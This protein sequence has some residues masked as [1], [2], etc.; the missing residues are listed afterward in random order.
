MNT[1]RFN[2]LSMVWQQEPVISTKIIGI[3]IICVI[4]VYSPMIMLKIGA[5]DYSAPK[6]DVNDFY[7][8]QGEMVEPLL[9]LSNVRDGTVP[10]S[11][12]WL[13]PDVD[14]MYSEGV[15]AVF[16]EPPDT[17][18]KAGK[19]PVKIR[20]SDR[21]GNSRVLSADLYVFA[22]VETI[23]IEAG[24]P[25]FDIS[26]ARYVTDDCGVELDFIEPEAVDYQTVGAENLFIVR[27]PN[28]DIRCFAIVIDSTPPTGSP[29]NIT[30]STKDDVKASDLVTDVFD[31]S[32][33][34]DCVFADA[35]ADFSKPGVYAPLVDLV[36][37][38]GNKTTLTCGLTIIV[39]TESPVIHGAKSKTIPKKSNIQYRSGVTVTD[40][41]DIGVTLE[42]DSSAV[43]S[44]VPGRYPVIYTASDASGN[45][46]IVEITLTIAD[47]D[48]DDVHDRV[49]RITSS[50]IKDGMSDDE[51]L[52][53]VYR[54]VRGN[55]RY[56][57]TGY[58]ES[59]LQGAHEALTRGYGDC[60]TFYAVSE[61]LL[62]EA[63]IEN[64]MI[65]RIPEAAVDHYWNLVHIDGEWYHFDTCPPFVGFDG[66]KFTESQ[67]RV[68]AAWQS[69]Y[70]RD[71]FTYVESLYP[72]V[73]E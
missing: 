48:E 49:D 72:K 19:K 46:S 35:D 29:L 4:L 52:R 41:C 37:G 3:A 66:C 32:G 22:G 1:K 9:F 45:T 7:I 50:I 21:S 59:V 11:L 31:N 2:G 64:M 39:D 18:G 69:P 67:K 5:L 10:D 61:V 25:D 42:I 14:V 71:Y 28:R 6:A 73:V 57:H 30:A 38:S 8:H 17:T 54:W 15:S 34:V 20:L 44:T 56:N 16:V 12:R 55:V 33:S 24:S 70:R 60:Y 23:Y 13:I 53:A 58:T 68:Y 36:D 51:K 63:G 62:T 43:N 27:A 47:V 40:E 65:R 26:L